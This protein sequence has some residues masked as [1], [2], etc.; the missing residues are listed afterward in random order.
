MN[1]RTGNFYNSFIVLDLS[2]LCVNLSIRCNGWK[3]ITLWS[4]ITLLPRTDQ[5][6]QNWI[7][8]IIALRSH[9][10]SMFLGFI[11]VS[12]V[13]VSL[14]NV[15]AIHIVIH[16]IQNELQWTSSLNCLNIALFCVEYSLKRIHWVSWRVVC[17]AQC[18]LLW[19]WSRS[20]SDRTS[21]QPQDSQIWYCRVAL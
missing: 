6:C 10:T 5:S 13:A 9:A 18:F 14:Q 11:P 15:Q 16:F 2:S 12:Y 8:E 21:P 20:D 17:T 19:C 1:C 7:N 3:E 4:H